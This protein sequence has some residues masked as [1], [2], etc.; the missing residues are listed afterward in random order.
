MG[1]GTN[2]KMGD[3]EVLEKA[4]A[5]IICAISLFFWD[6]RSFLLLPNLACISHL[7][8]AFMPPSP[9][10]SSLGHGFC[11]SS[12]QCPAF[13][14]LSPSLDGSWR[15]C[16]HTHTHTHTHALPQAYGVW[17]VFCFILFVCFLFW[18]PHD[19]WGSWN[20]DQIW[21]TAANSA[22]VAAMPNPLTR[23]PL[24][25]AGGWTCVLELQ[26]CHP[27]HCAPAGTP[28]VCYSYP[29]TLSNLRFPILI[30]PIQRLRL[31][32][33]GEGEPGIEPGVGNH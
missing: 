21:A 24:C 9:H 19:I 2:H 1:G 7:K 17:W 13:N 33:S 32:K 10:L 16:A 8:H 30:F 27:S 29:N 25:W 6:Q 15:A 26:R 11:G 20:R 12:T 31:G 23:H 28:D 4:G 3:S 18:L 5:V 22:A 14:T